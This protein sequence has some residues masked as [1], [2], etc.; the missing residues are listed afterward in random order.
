MNIKSVCV[1]ILILFLLPLSLWSQ[2][3]GFVA[4]DLIREKFTEAHQADQRVQSIAEEWKRE[5]AAMDKSIETLD[6]D[7][8]KNRLIWGDDERTQKEKE[9]DKLK[10]ERLE[11]SRKKYEPGGEWDLSVKTIMKPVEDKIYAAIQKISTDEGYDLVWDKSQNPLIYVNY[12][13]DLTLKVLRELG[14]DVKKLEEEENAK[15]AKD[16]RN[17]KSDVKAPPKSRARGSRDSRE[18][19]RPAE[20][21]SPDQPPNPNEPP[22]QPPVPPVLPPGADSTQIKPPPK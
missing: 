7:I 20:P 8:K 22:Q 15:I 14:V 3:I 10:S 18:V 6:A 11:Y 2:R 17:K 4:T 21:T 5:L 9:L 19:E 1:A 16:P 12:K 13:Y